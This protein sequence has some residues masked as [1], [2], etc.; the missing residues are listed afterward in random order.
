MPC[1]NPLKSGQC[2]LQERLKG[3]GKLSFKPSRNPLKSGQCFL[4]RKNWQRIGGTDK[5]RNPLKSGQCFLHEHTDNVW[6]ALVNDQSQSPQ[7]GS[8]FLTEV[9]K[10]KHW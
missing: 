10:W 4:R 1:R 8:M 6:D 3:I 7:I 2:F 9:I 5:G